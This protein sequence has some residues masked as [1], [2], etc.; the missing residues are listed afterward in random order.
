MAN[1]M[2]VKSKRRRDESLRNE[3][4][5]SMAGNLTHTQNIFEA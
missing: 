1:S 4:M 3:E 2:I 5:E